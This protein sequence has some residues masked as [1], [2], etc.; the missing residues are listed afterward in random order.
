MPEQGKIVKVAR[1]MVE[2]DLAYLAN[3]AEKWESTIS[4]TNHSDVMLQNV[5]KE[6][7]SELKELEKQPEFALPY[8]KG[9]NLFKQKKQAILL[10]F[11]YLYIT[12]LEIFE[13]IPTQDLEM[14]LN[15]T[16]V[17]FNE[18]SLFHILNRHFGEVT[19]QYKSAKSFH[20]FDIKPR[21]LPTQLKEILHEIDESTLLRG[22][23][24]DK[25]G[26]EYKGISYLIWTA[27]RTK[28]VKGLGNI[29]YRRIET[30]YP[31]TDSAEKA[32]LT[33]G[34]TLHEIT[35]KLSVYVPK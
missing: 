23:P 31:V 7:R 1:E 18:Y 2:K 8:A 21:I 4:T 12:A 15:S 25:I 32:K 6:A 17:E 16:R 19:K 35:P 3:E 26:F 11:K 9:S 10:R 5:S 33:Q 29:N 27:E 30:F 13:L 34:F 24:I 14:E 22:K 28:S 20:G